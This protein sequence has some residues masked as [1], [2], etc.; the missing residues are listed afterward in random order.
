M[1]ISINAPNLSGTIGRRGSN[2]GIFGGPLGGVNVN[3]RGIVLRRPS[4]PMMTIQNRLNQRIQSRIPVDIHF[5]QLQRDGFTPRAQSS[6]PTSPVGGA[7]LG[8]AV[9][10]A[11]GGIVNK[12]KGLLQGALLGAGLGSIATQLQDR[13]L[14]QL[15]LD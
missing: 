2:I 13:D 5:T 8:A 4:N 1:P 9:G 14:T 15:N 10:T 6:H 3:Q 7:L 11:V 12:R